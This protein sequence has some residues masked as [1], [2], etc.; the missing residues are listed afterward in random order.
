MR[1]S[2]DSNGL[3]DDHHRGDRDQLLSRGLT[4]SLVS[5][6]HAPLKNGKIR[7]LVTGAVDLR[8]LLGTLKAKKKRDR[9]SVGRPLNVLSFSVTSSRAA[10][11][12]L[13]A[14]DLEE[15]M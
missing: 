11:R 14:P 5:M 10:G 6:L 15:K 13:L 2:R 9:I 8:T 7:K 4:R 12:L 1:P 3:S